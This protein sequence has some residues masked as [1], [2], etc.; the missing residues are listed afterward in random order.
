MVAPQVLDPA[1]RV[2]RLL[3]QADVVWLSTVRPDGSPH[4]VPIWFSWDG[5]RLFIASKPGAVKVRNLRENQKVMFAIGDPEDDFDVGMADGVAEIPDG[6]TAEL[7]PAG[8]L[9]KYRAQMAAMGLDAAEYVATYS[10]PVIVTPTR[11]LPWHGRSVPRSAI[12]PQP[13]SSWLDGLRQLGRRTW[14]PA[15][16]P[17]TQG[18]P[19]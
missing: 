2:D 6:T 18:A 15:F 3:H 16:R 1:A 7:I 5:H 4:L 12:A 17:A 9:E 14:R 8:H 19:A 11:C 13:K 10:Q